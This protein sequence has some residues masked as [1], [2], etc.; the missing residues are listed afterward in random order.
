M[1]LDALFSMFE[2]VLDALLGVVPDPPAFVT[3]GWG[4]AA[5]VFEYAR[6][7]NQYVPLD[8]AVLAIGVL[9]TIWVAQY[10]VDLTEWVLTKLHL[11]GGSS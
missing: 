3:E 7:A 8:Q 6:W 1:I 11:L 2:G 9:F 10:A 4:A 5:Q